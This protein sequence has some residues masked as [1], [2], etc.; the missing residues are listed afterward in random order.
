MMACASLSFC[1]TVQNVTAS[2]DNLNGAV[3]VNY[4]LLGHGKKRY[5]VEVFCSIDGGQTFSDALV[6]VS[7]DVGYNVKQGVRNQ[8]NWAYFVDMPD[9]SGKNV[10]MKVVAKEDIEY[11]ENIILSLGG[12]EKFYQSI[13]LPGYGNYHVRNGKRYMAIT[14]VVYGLIGAGIYYHFQAKNHYSDYEKSKNHQIGEANL[15]KAQKFLG[16][17]N[18]LLM[19]G[20]AIWTVDVGQVILKGIRN[21]K[22]QRDILKRRQ[23]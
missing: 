6:G 18:G 14:G 1:Q 23:K 20:A 12:P 22:M 10:V 3:N 17:S 21:R 9:F 19:G 7:R 15:D 5:K 16:L 4:D 8:I 2:F 13:I 11:K